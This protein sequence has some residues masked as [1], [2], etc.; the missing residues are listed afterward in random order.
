MAGGDL[1]EVVRRADP[2]RW[3]AFRFILDPAKRG[4]AL[5]ILAFEAELARAPRVTSSPLAAQIRLTWWRDALDE[6]EQGAP[7][8]AHPVVEAL[9]A[10][11]KVGLDAA[12]LRAD[13]EAR[14][15]AL[16]QP[17][18][19]ATS[20]LAFAD[21]TAG[22]I[23]VS[24]GRLLDPTADL[25]ALAA[26][27]RV[28]GLDQLRRAHSQEADLGELVRHSL[29]VARTSARRLS[30]EAF[31]AVLAATLARAP[32]QVTAWT[33]VDRRLRLLA[34]VATGRL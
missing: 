28:I 9:S 34:A 10:A 13:I 1:D 5:A 8:R 7:A 3:L 27:G 17:P 6:L 29:S 25:E 18:L 24:I 31:P 4:A 30:P 19:D 2:D 26:G 12:P 23:A 15:L 32:M 33:G 16:D 11:R 22:S 20:A 21:G 14:I